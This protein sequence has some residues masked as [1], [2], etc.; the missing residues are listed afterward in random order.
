MRYLSVLVL[1]LLLAGCAAITEPF[2]IEDP[3]AIPQPFQGVARNND[4][5]QPVVSGITSVL[6][7]E[8]KG[9]DQEFAT[10]LQRKLIRDLDDRDIGAVTDP[11]AGAWTLK[12]RSAQ[13]AGA[14]DK[15]PMRNVL[16]WRL[17]DPNHDLKTE[18]SVEYSGK[19]VVDVVPRVM[20]LARQVGDHVLAA[21]TPAGTSVSAGL[22]DRE[23]L[24][25]APTPSDDIGIGSINGAPGDGNVALARALQIELPLR[26]FR[27]AA[28]AS[29]SPWRIQCVVT[30][31]KENAKDDR[32]TIVWSLLNN[33]SK[34][35]GT[36]KQ[37][38]PVPHGSLAKKWGNVAAYAAQGAADG[39]QQILQ[40]IRDGKP[41]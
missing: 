29:K 12:G 9:I 16:I 5:L 23:M 27:V 2:G 40:Q 38:N 11:M 36:L 28:D 15:A 24:V 31:Q 14:D 22:T 8:P 21:V 25:D 4:M 35:A 20:E 6:V 19:G 13:V 3:F 33:Q 1:V 18:F 7:E 32:V 17:F 26:G 39:V 30:V 37:E 10:E 34:V 41:K